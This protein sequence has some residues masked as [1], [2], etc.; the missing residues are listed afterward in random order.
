MSR[1]LAL[2][3]VAALLTGCGGDGQDAVPVAPDFRLESLARERFYLNA[4][5]GRTVVLVFWNTT[6]TVCKKEMVELK[7]LR[8]EM[9]EKGLVLAAVCTDPENLET[10]RSI[11]EKLKIDYPVLLDAGAK[12]A[13]AYEVTVY[14]TTVIVGP[15][16]KLR[17][18]EE[19]FG[20]GTL[21]AIRGQVERLLEAG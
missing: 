11:A 16:G 18:R 2:V 20:A 14:P 9:K 5:R 10:A 17:F 6:C 4:Q 7:A 21:R 3:T 19:G 15:E 12:T 1:L 8:D 13:G